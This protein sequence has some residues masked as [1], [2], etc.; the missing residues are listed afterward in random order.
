MLAPHDKES[1]AVPSRTQPFLSIPVSTNEYESD[2][3]LPLSVTVL[4]VVVPGQP[5]ATT[6]YGKDLDISGGI[7]NVPQ[8]SI[9]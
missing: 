1:E 3:V 7:S 4:V 5:I 6:E 2:S 8:D 9:R